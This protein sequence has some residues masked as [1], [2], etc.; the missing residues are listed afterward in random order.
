M[1][2]QTCHA[3]A[4]VL[5]GCRMALVGTGWIISHLVA[6]T[7]IETIPFPFR[8]TISTTIDSFQSG[9]VFAGW[10]AWTTES[11]LMSRCG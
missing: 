1:H 5:V 7:S 3:M 11:S 8:G 10:R 4:I 9:G 2:I 6:Q